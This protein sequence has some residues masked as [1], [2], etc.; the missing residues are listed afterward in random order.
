MYFFSDGKLADEVVKRLPELEIYNSTFTSNFGVWALGFVA[1]IYGKDNPGGTDQADFP[2]QSVSS[3]DLSNRN[4]HNLFNK[5][6]LFLMQLSICFM[7]LLPYC[8]R[9]LLWN[10]VFLLIKG[11]LNGG[12]SSK[13]IS[14]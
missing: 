5:V 3:L 7:H 13:Y 2:L 12:Q 1:D 8:P 4:I 11:G 14:T 10:S 6:E 9:P